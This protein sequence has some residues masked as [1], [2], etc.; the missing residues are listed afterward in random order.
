ME[1]KPNETQ[2]KNLENKTQTDHLPPKK[3]DGYDLNLY[4]NFGESTFDH[5]V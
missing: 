3:S 2:N 1:Q 5:R 4:S